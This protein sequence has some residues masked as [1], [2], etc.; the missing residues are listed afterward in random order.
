MRNRNVL[1]IHRKKDGNSIFTYSFSQK[2][3]ISKLGKKGSLD[4]IIILLSLC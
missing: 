1:F 4:A 3:L 2:Y